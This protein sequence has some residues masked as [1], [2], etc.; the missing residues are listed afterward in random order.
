[1]LKKILHVAKVT[2]TP[3][4]RADKL[5]RD[6]LRHEAKIG[7]QLFGPVPKGG[8][9][10]FFC[11]DEHTWVWYEEWTDTKGN[12]QSRTTRYDIR[13]NG[14]VKAQDG[15]AYQSISDQEALRI[16]DAVNAY[17][18]R[19]MAEIYEPIYNR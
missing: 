3:Q 15:R 11:L 19:V 2:K 13:P 4:E 17:E 5:Q 1:M 7:G 18:R 6:L 12:K 8:R 10:D 16:R 14:I 9:R